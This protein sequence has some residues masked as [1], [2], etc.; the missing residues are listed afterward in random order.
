M[1][2]KSYMGLVQ[3][4]RVANS[5]QEHKPA[6]RC[7][8]NCDSRKICS[9]VQLPNSLGETCELLTLGGLTLQ[10]RTCVLCCKADTSLDAAFYYTQ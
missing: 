9:S 4:V 5:F 3:L 6:S 10:T 7:S 8:H 1:Q 2:K